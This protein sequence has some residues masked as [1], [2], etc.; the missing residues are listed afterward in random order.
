M[1]L[2]RRTRALDKRCPI[3]LKKTLP[4]TFT[5]TPARLSFFFFFFFLFLL[6]SYS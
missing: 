1:A 2:I 3:R 6:P 4:P 5:F